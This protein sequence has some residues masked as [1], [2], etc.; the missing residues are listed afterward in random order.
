M[1][2]VISE[3]KIVIIGGHPN[4]LNKL[5]KIFPE[6]R[7]IQIDE[8][9]R[10]IDVDYSDYDKVYF[11]TGFISHKDYYR[12]VAAIRKAEVSFGYMDGEVNIEKNIKQIYNDLF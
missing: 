11:F 8:S 5:K 2:I 10:Y 4:W 3:K 6:W 7:Y 12:Y 9:S 1:K